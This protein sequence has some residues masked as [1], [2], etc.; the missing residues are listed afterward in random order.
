MMKWLLVAVMVGATTAGEVL[1][2]LGM[3]RHG[4]IQDFRPTAI[5][6]ALALLARNG[7]VIASIVAMAI[8]FF[9]FMKLLSI[10]NLSFAVPV[11][12]VTYVLETILAKYVLKEQV[13]WQRWAG[14]SLVI[15]G[16]ALVSL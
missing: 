15:C 9:A 11:S 1:Q 4:E 13:N 7:H 8:S 14:A 12:A 3:R 10:S 16:V 5:G 2:A 6:R